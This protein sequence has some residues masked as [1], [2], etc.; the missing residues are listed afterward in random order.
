MRKALLLTILISA[1]N[2]GVLISSQSYSFS[3]SADVEKSATMNLPKDIVVDFIKNLDIYPKYF[4]DIV[5]VTKIND[6]D[7]EWLYRIKAPLASPYNLTFILT[8]RSP[9]KDTV[10]MESKDSTRDYLN[11]RAI[12]KSVD[13]NHTQVTM[14]FHIIMTREKASEVHFMAGILGESFLSA[15]M[16]EKLDADMDTF[17]SSVTKEMYLENRESRGN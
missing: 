8:D 14:R 13:E 12:F 6:K 17:I 4:P 11:C 10:I 7:S 1:F 9:S 15:R 5:S 3:I 16:K 2:S